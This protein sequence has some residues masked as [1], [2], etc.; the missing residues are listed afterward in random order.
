VRGVRSIKTL[1]HQGGRE[2]GREGI[3][4]TRLLTIY[5]HTTHR[6]KSESEV[7]PLAIND[8][9]QRLRMAVQVREGGRE[10]G[11]EGHRGYISPRH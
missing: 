10:G 11:R 3:V 6:P 4:L 9:A 7:L 5:I 2:G 1:R 8:L